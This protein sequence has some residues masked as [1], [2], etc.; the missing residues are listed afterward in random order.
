MKLNTS[1][2]VW[3]ARIIAW[4]VLCLVSSGILFFT[5]FM[6]GPTLFAVPKLTE[7]IAVAMYCPGAESTSLEEGAST[8]TTSSPSGTFGHTVEVTC[9]YADGHTDTIDNGEYAMASIGG[10]FGIGGLVGLGLSFPLMFLPFILI[11]RKKDGL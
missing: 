7:K 2:E 1:K 9:Y 3:I 5:T 11:R 8:Q 6:V 4:I 10:V